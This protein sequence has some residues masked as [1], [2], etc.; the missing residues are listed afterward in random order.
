M[1]VA[2]VAV[3]VGVFASTVFVILEKLRPTYL[4]K[5]SFLK[6]RNKGSNLCEEATV[7]SHNRYCDSSAFVEE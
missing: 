3:F 6:M 1:I 5:K 7:F 2:N 4:K